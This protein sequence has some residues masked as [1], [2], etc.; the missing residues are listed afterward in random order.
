MF[1]ALGP[2]V[3]GMIILVEIWSRMGVEHMSGLKFSIWGAPR[4]SEIYSDAERLSP[5][6][7][8]G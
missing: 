5:V 1:P 7:P 4:V 6:Y 8:V 3:R 2:V